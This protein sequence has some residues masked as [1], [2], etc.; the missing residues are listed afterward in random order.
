M[1]RE[2]KISI[3]IPAHNEEEG[4]PRV[5]ETLPDYI[6]EVIVVDSFS[7]DRTGEIAREM[8]AQVVR[9]D[10]VGYG[11]AYKTG[12]RA[13]RGD[14]VVT[15]DADG[16]YP[17]HQIAELL[18]RAIGDDLDFLSGSRFPLFDQSAMR[19]VN[20]VGNRLM[21][22]AFNLI[23]LRWVRDILSGMWVIRTAILPKLHLISDGWNFSEEIKIE[24][25]LHP[26]IRFAE[27]RI[28][29]SER[30][31]ETKLL[32]FKVGVENLIFLLKKRGLTLFRRCRS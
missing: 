10:R 30:I 29:Y 15:C 27:H 7:S 24:A 23:Y 26:S 11:R 16:T 2:Y 14:F 20:H 31:G 8:G 6:D 19:R 3:V 21:T 25:M 32:P 1:Y 22:L 28:E 5:L 17:V 13:V 9:E 18:D 4:L 12:F